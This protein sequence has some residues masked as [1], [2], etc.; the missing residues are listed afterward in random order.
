MLSRRQIFF[1]AA[2]A[3]AVA[4]F[5]GA[6]AQ[7]AKAVAGSP[8]DKLNA[9]F[10]A[11]MDENLR[12][13]PEFATSLGVDVGDKAAERGQLSDNSLAGIARINAL[14]E[15][16]RSRLAAFDRS[17]LTPA[18]KVSYDIILY[19]LTNQ[20]EAAKR[21]KFAGGGAGSPY[22]ISQLGGSYNGTPDFLDS[23]HPIETKADADAYIS[24]LKAFA[25]S[26][27][28]E[29][30]NVRHDE[31]LGVIPPDFII[32]KTLL[33]MG[34]LREQGPDKSV[35][36]Q[37]IIRRT[38]EKTIPGDW[39]AQATAIYT[40]QILPA[41]DRQIA[42]FKELRGKATHDAGVWRLPD[43]E[44]YYRACLKNWATTDMAPADIHKI[45]LDLVADFTAKIDAIMTA[46]GLTGGTVGERL[47]KMYEDPKYR[48]PNTDEAKEKLIADLNE[49]VKAVQAKLPGYF[50]TLPKARLEIKRVPKY[51]EA[52]APGGYYQNGSLDGTRPGYYYINL[53]DTAETP[54]WTLSTL[55]YHEGIPGHHLQLSIQQEADLPLIR[56]VSFF[57]AYI[58]G[59]ALYAEQLADEMGMYESDPWGR[60][61]YYHDAMFRAVRLVVDT[62]L[63]SMK[64]S[65]ERAIKYMVDVLGD[66]ETAATTEIERY[67]VWPGQACTY[68]LGKLDWLKNREKAKA[69]L[70]DKF[71]IGDFHDAGLLNGALPLAVLDEVMDVYIASKKG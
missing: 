64:W 25:V 57:S 33:L 16:Q 24:R 39:G 51:T 2:A 18:D 38:K 54:T 42:L 32:D 52:G 8:H 29:V 56:K 69:A 58:E 5:T 70:G 19:G 71:K 11:F 48:Y 62:G 30:A 50:N 7:A 35:L 22:F 55:T 15:S 23:T 37:S 46:Q 68:M 53:R 21:F 20:V 67:C 26:M 40:G 34:K 36:V 44:A 14:N 27:D 63:H 10:D 49:K 28:N 31:K 60:I 65:R 1:S 12:A 4:P 9:L 66:Q 41:L 59:W 47:R 43:G 6:L 61:G 17:S 45:G 3:A 13:A